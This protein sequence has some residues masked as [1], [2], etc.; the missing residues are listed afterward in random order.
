MKAAITWLRQGMAPVCFPFQK[1]AV[2]CFTL[3]INTNAETW[4]LTQLHAGESQKAPSLKEQHNLCLVIRGQNN[5]S[6]P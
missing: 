2:D 6:G 1:H 5:I 4:R 3:Q